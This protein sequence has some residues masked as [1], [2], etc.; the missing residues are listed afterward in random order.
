M[1]AKSSVKKGSSKWVMALWSIAVVVVVILILY[2]GIPEVVAATECKATDGYQYVEGRIAQDSNGQALYIVRGIYSTGEGSA[3]GKKIILPVC[4]SRDPSID[5]VR[6]MFLTLDG[7]PIFLISGAIGM[8]L[9][10]P[11]SETPQP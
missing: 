3:G 9:T 8:D 2:Y 10:S 1:E 7:Q 4:T 6:N 5:S 11:L